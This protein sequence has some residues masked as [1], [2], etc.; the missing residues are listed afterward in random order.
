MLGIEDPARGAREPG[1]DVE[2]QGQGIEIEH[3]L[4]GLAALESRASW[5]KVVV[6]P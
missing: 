2:L 1:F 3:Q 4:A 6:T 5:G